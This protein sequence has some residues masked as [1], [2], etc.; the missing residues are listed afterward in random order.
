[1]KAALYLRVAN[2][3]QNEAISAQELYLRDWANKQ[4]YEVTSAFHDM[5]PG[6]S[7]ERPGLQTLLSALDSKQFD[8]VLVKGAD[9]LLRN[10]QL[11]PKLADTFQRAGVRVISPSEPDDVFG[12]AQQVL[13]A[14]N[15]EWSKQFC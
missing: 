10:L 14:L 5:A 9:R 1:M 13:T 12:T 7:L 3:D 15:A 11:V 2:D 4:G 6:T 8:A